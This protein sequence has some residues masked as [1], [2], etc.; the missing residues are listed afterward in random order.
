MR[1]CAYKS[2]AW[3]TAFTNHPFLLK[4]GPVLRFLQHGNTAMRNYALNGT[5]VFPPPPPV[6]N[7][8]W[9]VK[10][11]GLN[12]RR[13]GTNSCDISHRLC[14]SHKR[15]SDP[16]EQVPRENCCRSQGQTFTHLQL[17]WKELKGVPW[18]YGRLNKGAT[19]THTH[20]HTYT[21]CSLLHTQRK[22]THRTS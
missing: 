7:V 1:Y 8:F 6:N 5:F 11:S 17:Q 9:A 19:H 12:R 10:Q 21:V 2:A 13:R 20:T 16:G 4:D 3:V 14:L 15:R 22:I 18:G